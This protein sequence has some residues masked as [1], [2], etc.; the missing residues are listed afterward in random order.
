[1]FFNKY[2][3][4]DSSYLVI[5]WALKP[6]FNCN[7]FSI[8]T[9]ASFWF[10]IFTSS[11]WFANNGIGHNASDGWCS[12]M[13]NRSWLKIAASWLFE[14]DTTGRPGWEIQA[15]IRL[16]IGWPLADSNSCHKSFPTV[17]LYAN[18]SKYDLSPV[19]NAS[20]P[21][22]FLTITSSRPPLA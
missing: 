3:R 17:F 8:E 1:M 10:K 4:V 16:T 7:G 15:F 21:I 12:P 14:T 20:S 18:F 9:V 2:S 13:K 22:S 19:R 5:K 6:Q 11:G